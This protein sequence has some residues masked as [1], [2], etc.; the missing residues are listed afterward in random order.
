MARCKMYAP[1]KDDMVFKMAAKFFK[2]AAK[3]LKSL[4]EIALSSMVFKINDIF[5]IL[6]R[7]AKIWKSLN[8][9]QFPKAQSLVPRELQNLPK[10]TLISCSS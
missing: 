8:I 10:I 2:M 3:K 7:A 9:S 1:E 4:P 6:K 5:Q